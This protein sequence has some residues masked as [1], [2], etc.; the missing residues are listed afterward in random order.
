[1]IVKEKDNYTG[2]GSCDKYDESKLTNEEIHF[3]ANHW[4]KGWNAF[5]DVLPK[6]LKDEVLMSYKEALSDSP[7]GPDDKYFAGKELDKFVPYNREYTE[8]KK[9]LV[10][11]FT[12]GT[13]SYYEKLSK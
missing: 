3:A 8:E 12:E 11:Y 1:M 10:E 2:H 7:L 4:V 5:M 6:I 9:R 13:T